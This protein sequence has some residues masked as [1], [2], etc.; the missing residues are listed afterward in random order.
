M[1]KEW[2]IKAEN[3]LLNVENNLR[4]PVCPA[5]TVCFHCHQIAEKYLK[6]F[7]TLH[8]QKI[9][10]THNLLFLYNLYI[11]FDNRIEA[12]KD[13]LIELNPFSIASRYP[14]SLDEITQEDAESAYEKAI[15]VRNLIISIAK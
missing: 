1:Y 9:E 13:A 12:I 8:N 7:L 5:D 2:F 3:D 15:H 6:G 4:A 14:F 11:K 10:K